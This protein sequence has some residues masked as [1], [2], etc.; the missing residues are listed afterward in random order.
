M[1]LRSFWFSW[2]RGKIA[3]T[4]RANR[5]SE[6]RATKENTVNLQVNCLSWNSRKACFT[7][8]ATY[9]QHA[10]SFVNFLIVVLKMPKN[11]VFYM[12]LLSLGASCHRLFIGLWG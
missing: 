1:V 12:V 11:I 7:F 6:K 8:E 4:P 3:D 2:G 10:Q 5:F 9:F